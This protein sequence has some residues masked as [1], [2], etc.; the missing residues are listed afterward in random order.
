MWKK[1]KSLHPNEHA[2]F[3]SVWKISP[4]VIEALQFLFISS[5]NLNPKS[6]LLLWQ[7]DRTHPFIFIPVGY[8]HS[9]YFILIKL[10]TIYIYTVE[11]DWSRF[12]IWLNHHISQPKMRTRESY[13]IQKLIILL[14]ENT[15]NS[16]ILIL[17]IHIL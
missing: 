5:N 15:N 2:D 12:L 7:S 9:R 14:V 10:R 4:S 6:L 3:V 1:S 13:I 16:T 11:L 17:K 8:L